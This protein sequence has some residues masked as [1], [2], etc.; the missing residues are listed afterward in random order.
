[1]EKQSKVTNEFQGKHTVWMESSKTKLKRNFMDPLT[2]KV[3]LS[4]GQD[5][6]R[7]GYFLTIKS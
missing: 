6:E 2:D 4:Q 1:M 7:N 5:A 3:H